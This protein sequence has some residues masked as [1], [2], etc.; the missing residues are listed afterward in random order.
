MI[1]QDNAQAAANTASLFSDTLTILG[2]LTAWGR[3]NILKPE[4]TGAQLTAEQQTYVPSANPL[5]AV[6]RAW[7]N[8]RSNQAEQDSS[9][10]QPALP[11]ATSRWPVIAILA[12]AAA[13]IW[14][15]GF[16][17]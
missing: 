10:R 4:A 12:A 15:F 17:R 5:G 2:G 16:R 3:E 14:Y 13:A 7:T 8:D 11:V 1:A 6:L 9:T